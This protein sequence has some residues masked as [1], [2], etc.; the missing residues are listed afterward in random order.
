MKP[1][2]TIRLFVPPDH[3]VLTQD[4]TD[5][6]R[7]KC[8]RSRTSLTKSADNFCHIEVAGS[9]SRPETWWMVRQIVSD[10]E[11]RHKAGRVIEMVG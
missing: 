8:P 2:K 1:R 7:V 11:R 9:S 4:L 6:I 5:A 10:I 3:T